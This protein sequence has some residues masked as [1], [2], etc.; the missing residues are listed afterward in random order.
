MILQEGVFIGIQLLFPQNAKLH[1]RVL[2][3][4][5]HSGVKLK[6]KELHCTLL[7]SVVPTEDTKVSGL[8]N[9]SRNYLASIQ[10]I[11]EYGKYLVFSLDSPQIV[12]RHSELNATGLLHNFNPYAPHMTIGTDIKYT[13]KIKEHLKQFIGLELTFGAEYWEEPKP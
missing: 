2:N 3:E 5:N 11:E 13:A 7:H 10:A 6:P 9:P 4:I 12:K 1:H 8:M